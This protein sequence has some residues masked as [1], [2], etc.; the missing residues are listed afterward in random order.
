MPFVL[1]FTRLLGHRSKFRLTDYRTNFDLI[2]S[3][4]RSIHSF[5]PHNR[6]AAQALNSR[7]AIFRLLSTQWASAIAGATVAP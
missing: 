6:A 1:V 7:P 5:W 2:G 4:R 3:D